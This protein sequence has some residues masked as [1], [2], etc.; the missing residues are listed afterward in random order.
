MFVRLPVALDE[1][2]PVTVYVTTLPTG[3]STVASK[4]SSTPLGAHVPPP[5]P[6]QVHV[7]PVNAA[8]SVSVTVAPGASDGP[9]LLDHDLV[10]ELPYPA[11]R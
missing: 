1:T 11:R 3:R 4:T 6:E 10:R 8:G 9:V 7:M 2:V 5:E